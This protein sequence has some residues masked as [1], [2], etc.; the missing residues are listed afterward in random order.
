MGAQIDA[1]PTP[2]A[3]QKRLISGA[4]LRI[5]FPIPLQGIMLL[6]LSF[7]VFRPIGSLDPKSRRARAERA[8]QIVTGLGRLVRI[9]AASLEISFSRQGLHFSL[10]QRCESDVGSELRPGAGLRQCRARARP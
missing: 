7:R 5:S 8:G 10:R 2:P 6:L 1:P 4:G 3:S 9:S